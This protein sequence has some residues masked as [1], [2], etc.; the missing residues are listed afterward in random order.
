MK[1]DAISLRF[2]HFFWRRESVN[3][4]DR[5]LHVASLRPN[6]AYRGGRLASRCDHVI[7]HHDVP[8]RFDYA[9]YSILPPLVIGLLPDVDHRLLAANATH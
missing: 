2:F 8:A 4:D 3:Q 5:I 7:D 6:R 1:R 9:V